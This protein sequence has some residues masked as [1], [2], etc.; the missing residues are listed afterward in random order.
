MLLCLKLESDGGKVH[1]KMDPK[2][3]MTTMALIDVLGFSSKIVLTRLAGFTLIKWKLLKFIILFLHL[4][5]VLNQRNLFL[6]L[7]LNQFKFFGQL[8]ILGC[9]YRNTFRQANVLPLME[10]RVKLLLYNNHKQNFQQILKQ[11]I[12]W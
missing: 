9:N 5:T 1:V 2:L 8:V 6:Y 4:V 10:R 7:N 12:M 11:H 3:R